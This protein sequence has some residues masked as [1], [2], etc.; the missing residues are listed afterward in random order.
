[1]VS[2][3]SFGEGVPT[4]PEKQERLANKAV[5]EFT[6][7]YTSHEVQQS[8]HTGTQSDS[9]GKDRDTSDHVDKSESRYTEPSLLVDRESFDTEAEPGLSFSTS[10]E[11]QQFDSY[12]PTR[13]HQELFHTGSELALN[14]VGATYDIATG[15]DTKAFREALEATELDEILDGLV[16]TLAIETAKQRTD[17]ACQLIRLVARLGGGFD[18]L[19]STTADIERFVSLFELS[20]VTPTVRVELGPE[21]R[22]TRNSQ[23]RATLGYLLA[24]SQGVNVVLVGS[25]LD[26]RYLSK[27][28]GELLPSSVTDSCNDRRGSLPIDELLNTVGVDSVSVDLLERIADSPNG[29]IGYN[30]LKSE[31]SEYDRTTV[32]RYLNTDLVATGLVEKYGERGSKQ[33]DILPAGDEYLT[34]LDELNAVEKGG[35]ESV[36]ETPKPHNNT[37]CKHDSDSGGREGNQPDRNRYRLPYHH[38][39]EYLSWP[40]TV[41]PSSATAESDICLTNYPVEF[42]SDRAQGE[43]G[44]KQDSNE[45]VASVEYDNPMQF[46]VTLARTLADSRTFDDVLTGERL[47]RLDGP[48]RNTVEYLRGVRNLGY[49]PNDIDSGTE[50]GERLQTARDNLLDLTRD[51]G[52]LEG[53]EHRRLRS[54][55]TKKA[56]GLAGTMMHLFDLLDIEVIREV[57][58]PEYS[59]RFDKERAGEVAATVAHHLSI[60]SSY[61]GA[62]PYRL[63]YETRT[64]KRNQSIKPRVDPTEPFGEVLGRVSIVGDFGNRGG[65]F[66]RILESRVSEPSELHEK[67]PEIAIRTTVERGHSRGTISSTVRQMCS[68]KSLEATREA[69]SLFGAFAQTPYDITR[70]IHH[71]LKRENQSG[72]VGRQIRV[73]EVRRALATLPPSRLLNREATP[74]VRAMTKALLDTETPLTR[75]ELADRADISTQTVRNHLDVLLGSGIA[76]ERSGK[77][78]LSLSFNTD[79]ERH[80]D[81][82]PLFMHDEKT[83]TRDIV[84]EIFEY[85]DELTETVMDVWI[86]PTDGIP[87]VSQLNDSYRWLRWLE[88]VLKALTGELPSNEAVRTVA[89]GSDIEQPATK[90]QPIETMAV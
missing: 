6:E 50:F 9:T 90:G 61:N 55:I 89:F 26:R 32:S 14:V 87:D 43:W 34:Y 5:A 64:A 25:D 84:F 8:G 83:F 11:G 13:V 12:A 60:T 69:V 3:V 21:F 79:E 51:L 49:L 59:R 68:A 36:T 39:V 74:G 57:R 23:Q 53:D 88:P 67:A 4:D 22:Q 81:R 52:S 73:A 80:S 40:E 29:S 37:V 56:H 75:S 18:N 77:I 19:S 76:K 46:M 45:L 41:A 33:V 42:R 54:E 86:A 78:R 65:E 72:E 28:F 63:L 17:S 48:I 31:F 20:S 70:A 1:V 38:T 7:R 15:K 16:T 82:I 58:L 27:K 10:G 44:Y 85:L 35:S 66:K 71:G 62:V 24:L 2:S 47:G 30:R